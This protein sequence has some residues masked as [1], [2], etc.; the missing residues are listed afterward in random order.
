[1]GFC[2]WEGEFWRTV[3]PTTRLAGQ[4]LP[5]NAE[6]VEVAGEA[7]NAGETLHLAGE[8]RPDPVVLDLEPEAK[9]RTSFARHAPEQLRLQHRRSSRC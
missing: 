4:A 1:M 8:V 2:R 3:A 9:T 5:R 6:D 7:R